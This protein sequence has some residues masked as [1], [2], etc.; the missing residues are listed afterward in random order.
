MDILLTEI[1]TPL[2]LA[3]C[4]VVILVGAILQVSVGMGF[5]MLTAPL[6]ALIN[7]EL[8]PASILITGMFVAVC[9]AWRERWNINIEELKLGVAG[10][11]LGSLT[12]L[13][14]LYFIVDKDSFL[15]LFGALVL[16]AVIL[17]ASG[18][19][20]PF[21]RI[22]LFNLSILS[23][24]MGTITAVGAPPMA[25]IYHD[26]NPKIARPTLNAFFGAG[27]IFG[28]IGLG[29]SGWISINHLVIALI[30][31][32]AVFAGFLIAG[33]MKKQSSKWFSRILLSLSGLAS[34]I[35]IAR[36]I[37]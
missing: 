12:A 36:G 1:L 8:V 28:I 2:Q 37:L 19:K 7:P 34:V 25:I 11:V 30:F 22:N 18:L 15:I 35:L 23:G 31:L 3:M 6:I 5:G 32:P 13:V 27:S 21:T 9:S 4:L 24:L 14:F 10:R 29:Y 17:T 20:I 26:R 33:K 16:F